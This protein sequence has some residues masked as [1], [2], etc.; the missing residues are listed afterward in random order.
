MQFP[1]KM[2]VTA[3]DLAIDVAAGKPVPKRVDT[4]ELLITKTSTEGTG[5]ETLQF[6]LAN[7]W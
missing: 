4:G 2:A 7:C 5:T 1:K 3:V 6:G